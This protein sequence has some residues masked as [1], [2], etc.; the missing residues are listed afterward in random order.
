[1][2]DSAPG[3]ERRPADVDPPAADA[4]PDTDPPP[5]SGELGTSTTAPSVDDATGRPSQVTPPST[6]GAGG[7]NG[8]GNGQN[9]EAPGA[10][11]RP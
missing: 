2:A 3:A 9:A 6:T 10:T 1:V 5:A 4:R 7:A 8:Q 11:V